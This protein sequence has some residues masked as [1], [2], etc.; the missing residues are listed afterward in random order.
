MTCNDDSAPPS[1]PV[2]TWSYCRAVNLERDKV[3]TL[4][5]EEVRAGL[6]ANL[7]LFL[8]HSAEV[9]LVPEDSEF[10]NKQVITVDHE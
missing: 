10:L 5:N 1:S 6:Q 4:P 9:F 7:R 2:R 8:L 3:F